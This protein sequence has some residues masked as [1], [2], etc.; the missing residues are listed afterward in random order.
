M[1]RK[2]ANTLVKK[3]LAKYEGQIDDAPIGKKFSECYDLEKVEPKAEY[4]KL[5][6]RVREEVRSW[7][8]DYSV[9]RA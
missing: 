4:L 3:A 1:S 9:I 2:E 7:G 6:A 5:Y 8:L